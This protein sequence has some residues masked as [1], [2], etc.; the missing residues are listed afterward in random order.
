RSEGDGAQCPTACRKITRRRRGAVP[1]ATPPGRC[2]RWDAPAA[3]VVEEIVCHRDRRLPTIAAVPRRA[4]RD[5]RF[6]AHTD[7][8]IPAPPALPRARHVHR[9]WFPSVLT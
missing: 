3:P 6:P 9:T 2:G 4:G 5:D 1:P 7:T 8:A